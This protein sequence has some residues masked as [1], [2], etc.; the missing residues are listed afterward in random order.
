M[1]SGSWHAELLASEI[2][3]SGNNAIEAGFG[4][5]VKGDPVGL[6]QVHQEVS[7]VFL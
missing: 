2:G 6:C 7:E 3:E 5:I 4:I 1:A